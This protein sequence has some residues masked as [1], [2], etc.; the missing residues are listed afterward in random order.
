ML[1]SP[2]TD[3]VDG[4]NSPPLPRLTLPALISVPATSTVAG[5]LI[6]KVAEV[7]ATVIAPTLIVPAR[8]IW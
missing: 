1:T 2:P 7:L 5:L 4:A 6:C 8:L 3:K